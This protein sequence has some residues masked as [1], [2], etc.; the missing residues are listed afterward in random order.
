MTSRFNGMDEAPPDPIFGIKNK[1]LSDLRE[2]RLDL[3]AGVYRDSTGATPVMEAVSLAQESIV[4]EEKTKDYLPIA[5]DASFCESVGSL[6]LSNQPIDSWFHT[7]SGSAAIFLALNVLSKSGAR[8]LWIPDASWPNHPAIALQAG[9]KVRRYP[10]LG[11]GRKRAD[12]MLAAFE[13]I[14][15]RDPVLLHL[16]CQNPLGVD[17][18]PE[19]WKAVADVVGRRRLTVILDSAYIG[20]AAGVEED[21]APIRMLTD[22]AQELYIAVSFSKNFG[23]YRER[24]GALHIGINEYRDRTVARKMAEGVARSVWSNPPW[25]GAAI[26]DRVLRDPGLRSA[27]QGELTAV[28]SRMHAIRSVLDKRSHD[29]GSSSLRGIAE[30]NG[31]F[32]VASINPAQ[33]T[34]LRTEHAIYV[35][36]SG[37]LNIAAILED[38]IERVIEAFRDVETE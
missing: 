14:D 1:Y 22:V 12:K 10:Y 7:P 6:V 3:T 20:F 28:R 8:V 25:L 38:S 36:D 11:T 5:G 31:M 29:L 23:L 32:H 15:P 37:R 26:V 13:R 19:E 24:V 2:N 34:R 21:C 35:L 4:S 16:C 18:S 17:L 9:L 33:A 30:G 27:W